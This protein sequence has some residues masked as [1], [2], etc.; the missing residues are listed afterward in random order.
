L[1]YN[2]LPG[3]EFFAYVLNLTKFNENKNKNVKLVDFVPN[4]NQIQFEQDRMHIE[5]TK[6]WIALYIGNQDE[7]Y[8]FHLNHFIDMNM[9]IIVDGRVISDSFFYKKCYNLVN[10]KKGKIIEIF[11][12]N[13]LVKKFDLNDNDLYNTI[14][15][16]TTIY[17]KR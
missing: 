13:E 3:E 7:D 14:K 17:F 8:I 11:M 9:K 15:N 10:F 12:N 4:L 16:T 5:E 1:K 6:P 2:F